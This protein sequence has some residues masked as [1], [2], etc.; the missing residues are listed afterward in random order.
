MSSICLHITALY[1]SSHRR[2]NKW[3]QT[4]VFPCEICEIFKNTFFKTI[5][6][7]LLLFVPDDPIQGCFK[8]LFFVKKSQNFCSSILLN[9]LNQ[10]FNRGNNSQISQ[11]EIVLASCV[12]SWDCEWIYF[13][14]E[15]VLVM[16]ENLGINTHNNIT[17]AVSNKVSVICK[18]SKYYSLLF[19]HKYYKSAK[20]HLSISIHQ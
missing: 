2:N 18:N 3:L 15:V 13:F 17:E 8:F 11:A 20:R 19:F 1:R 14:H 10:H 16:P 4:H 9:A 7:R 12:V 6:K 5:C